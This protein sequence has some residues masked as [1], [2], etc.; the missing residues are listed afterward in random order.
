M[1]KI[2]AKTHE[3]IATLEA[4]D[5]IQNLTFYK[6]RVISNKKLMSLIE[7][8]KNSEN[9]EL[10]EIKKELYSNADYK[11]YIDNYN[12]LYYIVLKIN[13]NYNKITSNRSCHK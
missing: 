5:I 2:I 8:G 1:H 9:Q 3:L 6:E 10:I 13:K 4:S 7:K 12:E 11:N